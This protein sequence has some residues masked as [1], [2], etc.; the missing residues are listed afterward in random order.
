MEAI[1]YIQLGIL[2]SEEQMSLVKEIKRLRKDLHRE[3]NYL[4]LYPKHHKNHITIIRMDLEEICKKLNI[5]VVCLS[6]VKAPHMSDENFEAHKVP[7]GKP[8]VTFF[9]DGYDITHLFKIVSNQKK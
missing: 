1:E 4:K 9:K 6:L 5:M 2:E 3:Y 8:Y 7:E